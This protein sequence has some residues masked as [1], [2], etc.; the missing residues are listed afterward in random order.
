MGV[1]A[2]REEEKGRGLTPVPWP[3]CLP[4]WR[5]TFIFSSLC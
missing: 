4:S 5:P 1:Y 3:D 2:V